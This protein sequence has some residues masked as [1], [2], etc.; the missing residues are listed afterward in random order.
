MSKYAC[1]TCRKFAADVGLDVH[2][3]PLADFLCDG[4]MNMYTLLLS[5]YLYD[6]VVDVHVVLLANGC[7]RQLAQQHLHWYEE[8]Q[9]AHLLP[10]CILVAVVAGIRQCLCCCRLH[11]RQ[12]GL[13]FTALIRRGG[14]RGGGGG[15]QSFRNA[16]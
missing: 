5:D 11:S 6:G 9:D 14:R 4:V 16:D 13:S 3:V 2:T 8:L 10:T 12:K 1:G 7:R 15:L